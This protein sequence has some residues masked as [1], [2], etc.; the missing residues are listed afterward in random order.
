MASSGSVTNPSTG[1][2]YPYPNTLT[3]NWWVT[4]TGGNY[5][6]IH[7]ELQA[8]GGA[9]GSWQA[10]YNTSVW[11]SFDG[12]GSLEQLIYNWSGTAYQGDIIASGDYT[13]WHTDAKSFWIMVGGGYYS[14][15][16]YASSNAGWTLDALY[17]NPSTPSVWIQSKTYNS[18]TFGVSIGS[19]GN[20]SGVSGRYI[21]AAILQQNSY[22]ASATN[23]RRWSIAYNTT[24]ASILVNNSSNANGGPDGTGFTITGNTRYYYGGYATNTQRATS[25]VTGTFYT[26]CP[27]LVSIVDNLHVYKTF[28]LD[29]VTFAY[30]RANDGGAETRTGYYRYSTDGGSTF[31]NWTSFGTITVSSGSTGFFTA[32]FP[33]DSS[34]LLQARINTP[35]GGDSELIETEFDTLTTHI[36][37]NFSDFDYKD[38]N[39]ISVAV[40]GDNQTMVQG[41]SIPYVSISVEDKA[42]GN[43]GIDVSDYAITFVGQS[44]TIPY[45]S[46]SVASTTLESPSDSGTNNLV[47]AAVDNLA[48]STAVSKSVT[49]YPWSQPTITASIVRENNFESESTLSISGKYAPIFVDDEAKNT[50]SV[51]Y[52]TKKSSS[53]EWSEWTNRPATVD[54]DEWETQDLVISLDNNYQWDVQVKATDEFVSVVTDLVL[55]VGMPN[56]F[57]GT[58]GR[59]SV[60]MKPDKYMPDGNRGQLEV[61][62]MV[63]SK[64]QP[65]MPSHV[66]Q[67]IITTTLDTS[68]KVSAIYGGFWEAWGTGRVIVGMGSNG[69]TEYKT[70]EA[71]GGEEKH[72]LTIAEMPQH[73]HSV[74]GCNGLIYADTQVGEY[75]SPGSSYWMN[76]RASISIGNTG[77]GGSHE[78]RQPYITAY[79]WKRSS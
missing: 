14:S 49:V 39:P 15:R 55:S 13:I 70:V 32:S 72:K 41:Q 44:K 68:E 73:N 61:D 17:S 62:G 53:S 6:R 60:G 23:G 31:S 67:I 27:P 28:D 52:R 5:H 2:G 37:P 50:I 19:Y 66:G 33:T 47:V 10:F 75:V 58:D 7:W 65:L 46:S 51:S 16:N 11:I 38:N 63:Y 21:E 74:G 30:K 18:A 48:L 1:Y 76:R 79:M 78:N 34:I 4:E 69:T 22:D 20:P 57:I 54:D 40:T 29:S 26:P 35:N 42:T 3:V 36:A 9:G 71:T 24:S 64:G 8:T 77:G 43:D 59:V 56:F 45:R 25:T 12:C